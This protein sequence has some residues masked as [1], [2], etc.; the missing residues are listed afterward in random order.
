MMRMLFP[1]NL[2]SMPAW[3]R[4]TN[5]APPLPSFRFVVHVNIVIEYNLHH[6]IHVPFVVVAIVRICTAATTTA[7]TAA[8]TTAATASTA[9]TAT[10]TASANVAN[11]QSFAVHRRRRRCHRRRRR[12]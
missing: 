1:L 6:H 2:A 3:R 5:A 4:V 12:H 10:T 8:T 7:A 9:A 11:K